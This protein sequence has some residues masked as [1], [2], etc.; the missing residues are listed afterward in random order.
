MK[1]YLDALQFVLENGEERPDRTG[2][3]TI[4]VFGYQ[5]RFDLREKFPAVT[6]KRLAW[7]AMA[8]ELLWFIEGSDDERRLA[9]I[10]HGKPREEITD[11][12]TIW[13]DNANN[14][15]KALGY[16]DG[17]LGPVYGKNWRHWNP[18]FDCV[19]PIQKVEASNVSFELN[20]PTLEPN[21]NTKHK[22]I[23][24]KYVNKFG[25]EYI[26]IDI[27]G[28][29]SNGK[30]MSNT[31]TIQFTKT[32]SIYK[33]VRL[34]GNNSTKRDGFEPSLYGVGCLGYYESKNE[35][36]VNKRLRRTW[37]Q[38]ISR[39]YNK[40]DK[41]YNHYM[42]NGVYVCDRWLVLSNFVEDA[43][44]LAGWIKYKNGDN[45]VLDKDY[46]GNN[47]IYNPVTTCF[48]PFEHNRKYRCDSKPMV[49]VDNTG[50]KYFVSES[51]A[52]YYFNKRST[53]ALQTVKGLNYYSSNDYVIR[54]KHDIDQIQQLVRSIKHDPFGR[55]HI[56]TGWNPSTLDNVAL[57]SCH[58]FAQFYVNTKGELSCQLYQRSADMFLGV[59]FN[60]ASYALLTHIIAQVCGLKVGDFVWTGGDVHI[61]ANHVEQVKEQLLRE[62]KEHPTLWIDKTID[63]ID[64]FSMDSFKLIGYDPMDSI[65]APMAI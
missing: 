27:D 19:L 53:S 20:E 30:S 63:N 26:V 23:G 38:M 17:M 49:F 58:C 37:E 15:G 4:G 51:D 32:N 1:Q 12:R 29:V 48:V 45:V 55:R 50:E 36:C 56:I 35:S 31:F 57:P 2:T 52:K 22:H 7:K 33:K 34:V 42:S 47:N 9:E 39:C 46:Y 10:L 8:S 65:K 64:G 3:G 62:P 14:Q 43:K 41:S 21:K 40:N 24:K 28:Q 61:Y 44:E 25:Q 13:T 59:P 54:Y 18:N 60:I 5:M 11:K 16:D 6:T